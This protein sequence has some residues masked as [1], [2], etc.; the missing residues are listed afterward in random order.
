MFGTSLL[1]KAGIGAAVVAGAFAYGYDKGGE[2]VQSKW[3]AATDKAAADAL[4]RYMERQTT[5]DINLVAINKAATDRIAANNA[6][7]KSLQGELN[8]IRNRK[9]LPAVCVLDDERVQWA[10]RAL[11]YT[12]A[13]GAMR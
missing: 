12:G 3:D 13:D 11:G 1:W 4:Y 9:P 2:R 8:E 6:K 10:N 7:A 5:L